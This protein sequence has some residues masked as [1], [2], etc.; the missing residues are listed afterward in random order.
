MADQIN[1]MDDIINVESITD[2]FEEL[3]SERED[4]VSEFD[5]A[6]S[7]TGDAQF[8]D[9]LEAQKALENWQTEN[10]E[11]FTTL[12]NLLSEIEGMGGDYQWRGDWYPQSLIRDSH[13]EE[14]MD[15]TINECYTIPALPDF[16]TITLDYVSLRQDYSSVDIDGVEYLMR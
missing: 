13:F 16:M 6:C 5:E 10:N 7:T 3:E 11:E 1:N 4:L 9:A 15:E 8:G 2:R 14:Y 12:Q